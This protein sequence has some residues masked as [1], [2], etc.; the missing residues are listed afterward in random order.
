[1]SEICKVSYRDIDCS[2]IRKMN[3]FK[4]LKQ[5]FKRD[6][7]LL[8]LLIVVVFI[9]YIPALSASFWWVDDGTSL[10]AAIRIIDS[11]QTMNFKGFSFMF[12]SGRFMV[13][14]W[15]YHTIE[16]LIAGLNPTMHFLVHGVVVFSTSLFIFGIVKKI[17]NSSLAALFSALL[18]I[19]T[20]IN[21]ENL[22]RLGPQEPILSLF[23]SMSIYFLYQKK[24]RWA[25]A[26]LLI[27]ILTKENGFVLW[28]PFFVL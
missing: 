22:F 24:I 15:L 21:T 7:V 27:S 20:P 28:I 9:V 14:Y 16:Y 11:F 6:F 13:V 8:S 12:D 25:V 2:Q 23:I 1:M 10:A 5:I 17:T 19:L 4:L 18:Y 26:L 3:I